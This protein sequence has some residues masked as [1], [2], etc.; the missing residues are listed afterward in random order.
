[1]VREAGVTVVSLPLVNQWTQDRS[2]HSQE[3]GRTPRWRGI[4][5]LHELRQVRARAL[6]AR[7]RCLLH[8]C[9]SLSLPTNACC[10]L[11]RP[12]ASAIITDAPVSCILRW[13]PV[14]QSCCPSCCRSCCRRA[15]LPPFLATMCGTNFTHMETSTCWRFSHRWAGLGGMGVGRSK[16]KQACV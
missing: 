5:L 9:Q 8:S 14:C 6:S 16:R 1:M 13:L 2:S 3:C 10:C 7:R 12:V 11:E 4:T 15:S